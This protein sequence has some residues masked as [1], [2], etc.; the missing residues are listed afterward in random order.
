VPIL[1][2]VDL[3]GVIA[4]GRKLSGERLAPDDRLLLRTLANQS[5]IAIENAK[6]FDEIAKLNETL[7]ARVEER[8]NELREIQGQLMHAEKMKSLGQLV[9][10]VAHELN[11]PIGFVHANLQLLEEYVGKLSD[12]QAAG[13]DTTR[14]REAI[15]KLLQRSREGTQ[16]VKKIVQ[17]L[18]TFS[19]MDQAEIQEVDLHE[20][21]ERNLALMEPRFK[22]HVRVERDFGDLPRVRCYAGQLNQ[23]FLNLLINACDAM[24]EDGTIRITTRRMPGGVRLE[25]SDDGPGI[26][27][28]IRSRIFDP[29]FTTKPVGVG[30][31]L[32]LSLSHGIV[33][34]HGGRILVE[35]EPG[36]GATFVV[37]LPLDAAPASG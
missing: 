30:T 19:R 27:E 18:R 32:G 34:R 24:E 11:N 37:E 3:L 28:E 14:I 21:I 33:E 20:E 17:D 26:P 2:G 12:A 16:R 5:S 23:V 9:A 7:E 29:F 8:T 31:G 4:V 35:S 6:A 10:G 13:T 25:F 15:A 22:N 36:R 1:Y